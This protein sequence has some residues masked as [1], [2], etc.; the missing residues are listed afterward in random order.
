M[1]KH[2]PAFPYHFGNDHHIKLMPCY[3]SWQLSKWS[4]QISLGGI[5]FCPISTPYICAAPTQTY[6]HA[7][8]LTGL[9]PFFLQIQ[10]LLDCFLS[11]N[12]HRYIYT[13]L[14]F[15]D[16]ELQLYRVQKL[17]LTLGESFTTNPHFQSP[18]WKW[19]AHLLSCVP[20]CRLG[21]FYQCIFNGKEVWLFSLFRFTG[22]CHKLKVYSHSFLLHHKKKGGKEGWGDD[23]QL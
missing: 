18:L 13:I 23:N 10:A 1:S 19:R 2:T 20:S 16:L 14:T 8:S 11:P 6:Y 3:N 4:R 5:F 15:S 12:I 17:C 9:V 7:D 22:L 21:L